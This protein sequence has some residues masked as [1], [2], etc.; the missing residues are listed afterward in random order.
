[1]PANPII[2]FSR[3]PRGCTPG[4]TVS[5]KVYLEALLP[6]RRAF[7]W[8]PIGCFTRQGMPPTGEPVSA[9]TSQCDL[10]HPLR[11]RACMKFQDFFD[12]N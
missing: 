4:L 7:E 9:D 1:M 8:Q 11:L 2:G 6:F 5:R 12:L 10:E 3:K